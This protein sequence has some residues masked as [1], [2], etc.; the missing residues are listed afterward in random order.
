MT[1]RNV[2]IY[3]GSAT[4]LLVA[5]SA[6]PLAYS[7]VVQG[8]D[9]DF[10]IDYTLNLVLGLN[11]TP[12]SISG[13]QFLPLGSALRLDAVQDHQAQSAQTL[14]YQFVTESGALKTTD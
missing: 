11:R 8:G 1:T 2:T 5:G 12:E 6:A 13:S 4:S 9:A 7:W 14:T 10:G 3:E